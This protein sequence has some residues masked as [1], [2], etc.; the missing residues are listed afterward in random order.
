MVFSGR[1]GAQV[2][3]TQ[4]NAHHARGASAVLAKMFAR[5]GLGIALTINNTQV[6]Y[7]SLLSMNPGSTEDVMKLSSKSK[8][9]WHTTGADPRACIVRNLV[10]HQIGMEEIRCVKSRDI[11]D[12]KLLSQSGFGLDVLCPR[13]LGQRRGQNRLS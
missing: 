4:V 9:I 5:A 10:Q 6:L 3:F 11:P 8:V 1:S 2:I 12:S 13:T 7:V